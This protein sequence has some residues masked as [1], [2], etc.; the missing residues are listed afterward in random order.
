VNLGDRNTLVPLVV[1][2]F[3]WPLLTLY[4]DMGLICVGIEGLGSLWI[5]ILVIGAKGLERGRDCWSSEVG[6][7]GTRD[8]IESIELVARHPGASACFTV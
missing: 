4:R 3:Q 5:D 7:W 8:L 2:S 1:D 6:G